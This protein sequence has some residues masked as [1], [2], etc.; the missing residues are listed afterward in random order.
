MNLKSCGLPAITIDKD[1]RGPS[2]RIRCCNINWLV[3]GRRINFTYKA[4]P[5]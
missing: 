5:Q 3:T 1:T 4:D 2:R